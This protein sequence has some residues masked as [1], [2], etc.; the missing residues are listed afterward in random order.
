MC[1]VLFIYFLIDLP[2]PHIFPMFMFIFISLFVLT[3]FFSPVT[4]VLS[5]DSPIVPPFQK[6]CENCHVVD[7]II[8]PTSDVH[9]NAC[10]SKSI[11]QKLDFL[12]GS[13]AFNDEH[14]L[15]T[16]EGKWLE[17]FLH[18][19]EFKFLDLPHPK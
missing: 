12:C 6:V 8:S 13:I 4:G 2:F 1:M 17:V 19:I 14:V 5:I 16:I 7:V 11:V 3:F 15:L 18:M 9:C 10:H